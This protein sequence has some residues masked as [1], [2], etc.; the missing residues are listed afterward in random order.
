MITLPIVVLNVNSLL[1]IITFDQLLHLKYT[2]KTTIGSMRLGIKSPVTLFFYQ[3]FK[4]SNFSLLFLHF[5]TS[6]CRARTHSIHLH[7][8]SLNLLYR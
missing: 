3:K 7:V 5:I 2:R 8:Y 6:V 4:V 1:D